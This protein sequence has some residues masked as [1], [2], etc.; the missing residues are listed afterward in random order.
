MSGAPRAHKRA[1]P[2]ADAPPLFDEDDKREGSRSLK[3]RIRGFERLLRKP[4]LP[5][6]AVKDK[7]RLLRKLRAELESKNKETR[8]R[9]REAR[10]AE[11]YKAVRF[12][13]RRKAARARARADRARVAALAAGN[14]SAAEAAAA[15]VRAAEED[16]AYVEWFPR[17]LRYVSLYADASA[18]ADASL[19]ARRDA[20]RAW[21]RANAAARTYL[22]APPGARADAAGAHLD[23]GDGGSDAESAHDSDAGGSVDEESDSDSDS[24]DDDGVNHGGDSEDHEEAAAED[25]RAPRRARTQPPARAPPPVAAATAIALPARPAPPAPKP[26]RGTAAA[27]AA[28]DEDEVDEIAAPPP[29][30]TPA[31]NVDF[32][33]ADA[34]RDGPSF[35]ALPTFREEADEGGGYGG[36]G[37][38]AHPWEPRGATTAAARF[39][40]EALRAPRYRATDVTRARSDAAFTM[41]QN[42][43]GGTHAAAPARSAA[44]EPPAA[45]TA[46][47]H[48]SA[49]KRKRAERAAEFAANAAKGPGR[50]TEA[51]WGTD[52]DPGARLKSVFKIAKSERLEREAT[53]APKRRTEVAAPAPILAQAQVAPAA[54]KPPKERLTDKRVHLKF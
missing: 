22:P 1:R 46:F 18:S 29:S 15:A 2:F 49:R 24:S 7:T 39:E 14:A 28:A 25:A 31:G 47:D 50:F 16:A 19:A 17:H 37:A 32:F 26:R 51:A 33:F 44:P 30:S 10:Y 20:L 40:R 27:I 12:F 43:R 52:A 38:T 11:R 13:E 53:A 9:A 42:A 36:G 4:G 5:A 48:L 21:A 6:A 8:Q 41:N 45:D 23:G 35:S 3:N 34:V 54:A